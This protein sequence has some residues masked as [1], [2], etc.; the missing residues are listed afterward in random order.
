MHSPY[1]LFPCSI[2]LQTNYVHMNE[3]S[4]VISLADEKLNF[5]LFDAGETKEKSS[6]KMYSASIL[7]MSACINSSY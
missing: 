2:N 7:Y 3:R 1:V 6:Y 5:K 4:E